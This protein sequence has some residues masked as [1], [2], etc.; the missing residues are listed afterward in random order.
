AL[1]AG[2]AYFV[3][4]CMRRIR[5]ICD[6]GATVLFV[7]HSEALIAELCDKAMWVQNG[8]LLMV[9]EAE[10][11]AKAYIKRVCD[12][13]EESNLKETD[14]VSSEL[15]KTAETS[16]YMLGGETIRITRVAVLD[17]RNEPIGVVRNGEP[18][19]IR[20]EWEGTAEDTP[21]YSSFRIDS[22]RLQAVTGFEA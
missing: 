22:G 17:S 11:V 16:K 4:K 3:H 20:I 7:S 18:M 12:R 13:T 6:S 1:A 5:E 21:L 19:T 8:R 2:D 15:R 14:S 9:G 10:P